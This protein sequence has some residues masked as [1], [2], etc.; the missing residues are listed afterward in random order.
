[1]RNAYFLVAFPR[2]I[3]I[4][5]RQ[6][7]AALYE[8]FTGFLLSGLMGMHC[9][10][11]FVGV[12]KSKAFFF[13]FLIWFFSD[14]CTAYISYSKNPK[15]MQNPDLIFILKF[16]FSWFALIIIELPV[17]LYALC[18]D[19]IYWRGRSYKLTASGPKFLK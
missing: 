8:P 11:H 6:F 13:H 14:M 19:T 18:G 12:Q 10:N 7:A 9:F 4:K 17:Y 2:I 15:K 1:M 5:S 16:I 3:W